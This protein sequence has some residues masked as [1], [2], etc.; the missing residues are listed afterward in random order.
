LETV[1]ADIFP[2]PLPILSFWKVMNS[3]KESWSH[4]VLDLAL[5]QRL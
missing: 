3:I 5:W 4:W 1:E 2:L